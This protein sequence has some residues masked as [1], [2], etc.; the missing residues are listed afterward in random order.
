[1]ST[2]KK[3]GLS[4]IKLTKAPKDLFEAKHSTDILSQPGVAEFIDNADLVPNPKKNKKTTAIVSFRVD[5]DVLQRFDEYCLLK[6]LRTKKKVNRGQFVSNLLL[7]FLDN[8]S[9]S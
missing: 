8:N 5:S 4:S 7:S 9:V 3:T 2:K 6:Q 1:M